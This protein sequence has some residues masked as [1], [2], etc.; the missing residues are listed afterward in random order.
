MWD[1][2]TTFLVSALLILSWLPKQPLYSSVPF[3]CF[4][5]SELMFMRWVYPVPLFCFWTSFSIFDIFFR[6]LFTM[7]YSCNFYTFFLSITILLYFWPWDFE[8]LLLTFRCLLFIWTFWSLLS[9]WSIFNFFTSS[10]SV[11]PVGFGIWEVFLFSKL[12]FLSVSIAI[13]W[14]VLAAILSFIVILALKVYFGFC[15]L[16]IGEGTIID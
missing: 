3:F 12:Y 7:A 10:W 2:L 5:I 11:I 9:S 15:P 8:N 16:P 13:L 14:M 1:A 6:M 4:C